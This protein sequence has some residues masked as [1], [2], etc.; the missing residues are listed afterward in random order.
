MESSGASKESPTWYGTRGKRL[1][2][3]VVCVVSFSLFLLCRPI[4]FNNTLTF[5]GPAYWVK[6]ISHEV[7]ET[8]TALAADTNVSAAAPEKKHHMTGTVNSSS[9]SQ[10]VH[11]ESSGASTGASA[12]KNV[13]SAL[14]GQ[15]TTTTTTSLPSHLCSISEYP[16]NFVL[17]TSDQTIEEDSVVLEACTQNVL[18]VRAVGSD[19]QNVNCEPWVDMT[20]RIV[21]PDLAK[22]PKA[23]EYSLYFNKV[24]VTYTHSGNFAVKIPLLEAGKYVLEILL[25]H[26]ETARERVYNTLLK[27]PCLDK[28]LV[29]T[30][31]SIVMVDRGKCATLPKSTPLCTSGDVP[32][33]WVTVPKTGCDGS[34]CEG[35][36]DILTSS[37]RVWA[38]YDC[39]YKL[40]SPEEMTQCF[41][42]K[43]VL[44][45]GDSIT[46]ELTNEI[47]QIY[48][49][50]P[51]KPPLMKSNMIK[52][53]LWVGR[54]THWTPPLQGS[55][56][57]GFSFVMAT[58]LGC[59]ISCVT[60]KTDEQLQELL[61]PHGKIDLLVLLTG[62]HDACPRH[63]PD[64]FDVFG[65]YQSKLQPFEAKLSK[66]LSKDGRIIGSIH[67][68]GATRPAA[69]TS[70]SHVWKK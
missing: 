65:V 33:R 64:Y 43:N 51:N 1:G 48:Y 27:V 42:G 11:F 40:Y 23:K 37:G 4:Y 55:G 35:N 20:G 26:V 19:G 61:A 28:P 60:G 59:G 32:G 67:R 17:D 29:N 58:P 30:P 7:N 31:K 56:R 70:Q 47:L 49:Y 45:I 68:R 21:G 2:F 6:N 9:S 41:S 3:I 25:I 50:R 18:I 54:P 57:V 53:D 8:L 62:L 16:A 63:K 24:E 44:F 34:L 14:T 38:P 46:E 15:F 13:T 39:H 69:T 52:Q 12:K 36:L 66:I 22:I 10:I 5:L